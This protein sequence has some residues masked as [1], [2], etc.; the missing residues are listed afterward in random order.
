MRTHGNALPHGKESH[1]RQRL[2]RTAMA[3]AVQI[4]D[5]HGNV[6][7]AGGLFAGQPLPCI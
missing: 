6:G 1:A 7:F 5:A 4:G 3:F 2:G